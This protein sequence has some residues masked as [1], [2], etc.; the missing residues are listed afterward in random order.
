[1]FD[2]CLEKE[3]AVAQRN[4]QTLSLIML[5]IDYFKQYNDTYGH[6]QGDECLKK[7]AGLL[8]ETKRRP[9]DLIAR[10]GGE[11]FAI[12]L[13][14]TGKNAAHQL[15]ERYRSLIIDQ[16]IPHDCSEISPFLTV[17]IGVGS[18][19][20]TREGQ[21]NVFLNKVDKLLYAAK[22]KG[23]NLVVIEES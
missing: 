2:D 12:I 4:H 23:R 7:I 1:M 5:D 16:L 10:F 9:R 11:E 8:G 22:S 18:V 3:W 6:L 21:A 20:P 15:A 17:S 14:D 13:P 19:I